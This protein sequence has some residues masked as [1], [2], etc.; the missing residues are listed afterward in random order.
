M[1]IKVDVLGRFGEF[2]NARTVEKDGVKWYCAN[3][4][5]KVLEYHEESYRNA[6]RRHCRNVIQIAIPTFSKGGVKTTPPL[7]GNIQTMNFINRNDIFRLL[8]HSPMPKAED[9]RK[10]LF[11]EVIPS[12]EYTGGYIDPSIIEDVKLNPIKFIK[13]SEEIKIKLKQ[14]D[15]L[16]AKQKEENE[17]LHNSY[18]FLRSQNDYLRL[19]QNYL[20]DQFRQC[21]EVYSTE[22]ASVSDQCLSRVVDDL[23]NRTIE[24]I[25]NVNQNG[26]EEFKPVP[27][28]RFIDEK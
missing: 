23:V 14:R 17:E 15:E 13:E 18:D 9:F 25:E 27:L 11:D 8:D 3:D 5:L 10:W 16:I 21:R 19:K 22:L 1:E 2:G 4:I 20:R 6:L 26:N 7:S 12:I 28:I 24:F